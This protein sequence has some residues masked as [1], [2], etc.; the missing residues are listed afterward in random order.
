VRAWVTANVLSPH[1][2]CFFY[3]AVLSR[4]FAFKLVEGHYGDIVH[5]WCEDALGRIIDP[6][7]RQLVPGK[8]Y[9][10][11]RVV[12]AELNLGEVVADPLFERLEPVDQWWVTRRW[13]MPGDPYFV[14]DF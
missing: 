13:M 14:L 11:E 2:N 6:T 9:R 1:G 5:F 4:I 3:S 12:S 7:E 8:R 10:K